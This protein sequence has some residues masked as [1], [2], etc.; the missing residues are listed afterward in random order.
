MLNGRKRNW[1][2]KWLF[3]GAVTALALSAQTLS[4]V[5]YTDP[6]ISPN[7]VVDDYWELHIT[8]AA[9]GAEIKLAY[10]LNGGSI[11][12]FTEG[13]ADANG[14]FQDLQEVTSASLGYWTNVW[15]VNTVQVGPEFDYEVIDKPTGLLVL[16]SAVASPSCNEDGILISVHLQI[17]GASGS[18]V[19]PNSNVSLEPYESDTFYSP[20][21]T[22]TSAYSG[23]VG[24]N[25]WSQSS[26]YADSNA[27]FYDVPV[28]T[29][30]PS[31]YGFTGYR[32]GQQDLDIVIGNDSY[33]VRPTQYWYGTATGYNTGSVYNSNGD[34]YVTN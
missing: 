12:Y 9:A 19:L 23:D 11:G 3:L 14:N 28:G 15:Y 7:I 16:S 24:P 31:P 34:V 32:F 2:V 26:K 30:V 22:I 6:A 8:G 13:Y 21:G 5:N 27:E 33:P 18:V 17:T 20:S 10:T 4:F 25:S 1:L 29:C